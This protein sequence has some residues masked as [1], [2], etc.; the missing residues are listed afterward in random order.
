MA[1]YSFMGVQLSNSIA[2]YY[3]ANGDAA[4]YT[5]YST[6]TRETYSDSQ[7]TSSKRMDRSGWGG[8]V[9]R[10]LLFSDE[11]RRLFP[12]APRFVRRCLWNSRCR[13]GLCGGFRDGVKNGH[14]F[15]Q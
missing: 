7:P 9:F 11:P 8:A 10:R 5:S 6:V 3:A 13:R 2:T 1:N 4:S 12:T 15:Y 14:P